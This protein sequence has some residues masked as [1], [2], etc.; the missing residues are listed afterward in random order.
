MHANIITFADF[1]LFSLSVVPGQL[2]GHRRV[3]KFDLDLY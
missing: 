2:L 1:Q 3:A